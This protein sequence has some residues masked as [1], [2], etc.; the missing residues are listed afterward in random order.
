M[1]TMHARKHQSLRKNIW[2]IMH[3][4]KGPVGHVFSY[5]MIVLIVISVAILPLEF[6]PVLQQYA[7]VLVGME[8]VLTALFTVE[9]LLRIYGAPNRL[10][11]VFSFFGIID[12][13]SIL[14]FYLG[15]LGTQ[16]LRIFRLARII[17]V[18]QITL[19]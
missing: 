6:M 5:A 9:Y 7:A 10:Q 11:Y 4:C 18:L 2:D 1:G 14:P 13:M 17:R 8:I 16:Y 15:F 19:I 12:L 3:Y